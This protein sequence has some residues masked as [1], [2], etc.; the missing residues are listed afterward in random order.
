MKRRTSSSE[1]RGAKRAKS[2]AIDVVAKVPYGIAPISTDFRKLI[3]SDKSRCIT[4]HAKRGFAVN[5][6]PHKGLTALAKKHVW[7]N[8]SFFRSGASSKSSGGFARGKLIDKQVEQ[9]ARAS[10]LEDFKRKVRKPELL[11]ALVAAG[12]RKTGIRPVAAQVA[13]YSEDAKVATAGDI[14]VI[15]V[16]TGR[17]GFVELK[18][19]FSGYHH[20]G[21]GKLALPCISNLPDSPYYQHLLQLLLTCEFARHTYGV[22]T[23]TQS[24]VLLAERDEVKFY[25]IP[26]EL[27]SKRDD[28]YCEFIA[29]CRPAKRKPKAK[30]KPRAKTKPATKPAAK[31]KSKTG[32]KSKKMSPPSK[33]AA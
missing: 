29:K 2:T 6:V 16:R 30:R 1:G 19:G 31:S 27:L 25:P 33:V 21:S 26:Y 9:Y 3:A 18:C 24:Y 13:V 28:I 15:H 22:D 17:V 8:Y 11:T 7:P 5:R 12:L 4:Y 20:A 32:T 10:T 23:A 14:V